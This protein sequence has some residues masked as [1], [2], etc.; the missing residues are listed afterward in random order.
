MDVRIAAVGI[1]VLLSEGM[2]GDLMR[3]EY[4]A[5]V[6]LH[7]KELSDIDDRDT[8]MCN[9]DYPLGNA[10]TNNCS[11]ANAEYGNILQEAMC[12]QAAKDANATVV[13]D[14]F[15]L[16]LEWYD[17]HPKGCFKAE[18]SED[19][20]GV[21]Y[22]YNPI[23]DVPKHPK[24]S[25]VCSRPRY[26]N[27]TAEAATGVKCPTDYQ[28]IM[29]EDACQEAGVCLGFCSGTEFRKAVQN[30]S[31]F[32]EFPLGCFIHAE[33]DCVFFNAPQPNRTEPPKRPQGTPICNVSKTTFYQWV[34]GAHR[35]TAAVGEA[36]TTKPPTATDPKVESKDAAKAEDKAETPAEKKADEKEAKADK[37]E[38]KEEKKDEKK[39]EKK[40]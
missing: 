11:L 34:P 19:P 18:C 7:S 15:R 40:E 2:C 13:P 21:C 6:E 29:H 27:G 39:D 28:S 9:D 5:S 8:D 38:E 26:L 20:K 1:A 37:T 23:G 36:T 10:D 4:F 33:L 35:E 22:F 17:K 24:G 25:P 12:V 16:T 14:K 31:K 30:A 32:E 3:K